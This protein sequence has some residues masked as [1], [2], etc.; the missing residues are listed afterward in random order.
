MINFV[1]VQ[2]LKNNIF[3]LFIIFLCVKGFGQNDTNAISF[4]YVAIN[5]GG[6]LPKGDLEKRF[7]PNLNVGGSYL[8]KTKR[9]WQ[10]GV[11]G[12]YFFGQNVKEDVLANMKVEF[13]NSNTS[14]IDNEG[15]PADIRITERGLC[16]FGIAGRIFKLFK[17]N[18]N[19]GI[20]L[21]VGLGYMQHKINLY[22]AQ[23]K[24]AALNGE[25]KYGYDRLSNGLSTMQFLGYQYISNSRFVNFYGGVEF[26]QGYTKSVREFNYDTGLSDTKKRTDLLVGL[27]FGWIL[28]LY[29]RKP[30][31]YYY[32]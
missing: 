3:S 18:P 16:F 10:F 15:Y 4:H 2:L 25:L 22:D 19:T 24:I 14:I 26:I 27:R 21:N 12:N 17:S 29:K 31:E 28:P 13:N 23:K 8:F 5:F 1:L 7:G 6:H 32:Y 20:V 9:N 11:E 30:K